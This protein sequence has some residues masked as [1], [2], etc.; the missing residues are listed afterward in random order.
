MLMIFKGYFGW[1][2]CLQQLELKAYLLF[3][4]IKHEMEEPGHICTYLS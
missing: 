2:V 3:R 1:F 4:K